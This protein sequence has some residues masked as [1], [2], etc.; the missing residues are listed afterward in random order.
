MDI[1]SENE[2][3]LL[4]H[5][6]RPSVLHFLQKLKFAKEFVNHGFFLEAF[7]QLTP[8]FFFFYDAVWF[9]FLLVGNRFWALVQGVENTCRPHVMSGCQIP[10][11]TFDKIVA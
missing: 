1:H 2:L 8:F 6:R 5:P 11:P 4:P 10:L 3:Q 7:N 9:I